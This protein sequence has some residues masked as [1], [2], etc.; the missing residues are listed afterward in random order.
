MA[1]PSSV[2]LV[3]AS[4]VAS[5][6]AE[7]IPR[8]QITGAAVVRRQNVPDDCTF[9]DEATS[10]DQDCE[11]FAATWGITVDEFIAWV[12]SDNQIIIQIVVY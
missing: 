7:P 1:L 9:F 10:S 3:L 2:V 4:L 8:P 5:I 12:S 11:Y 6:T